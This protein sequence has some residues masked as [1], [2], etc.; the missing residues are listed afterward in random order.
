M[1]SVLF[2]EFE[3][4]LMRSI[5]KIDKNTVSVVLTPR[6]SE[7]AALSRSYVADNFSSYAWIA[8]ENPSARASTV[9]SDIHATTQCEIDGRGETSG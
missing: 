7:T 8:E 6:V 2:T 3:I 9:E 5:L 1:T 4:V